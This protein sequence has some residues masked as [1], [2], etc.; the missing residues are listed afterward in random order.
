[1]K[2]L[3]TV[4]L[5][6]ILV[7]IP[8][9]AEKW[10]LLVGINS[11]PNDI[12]N[13]EYCVAD[14]QAFRQALV[15]VAGFKEDKIFLMTDGMADRMEPTHINVIA[16]LGILSR[17]VKADDT[18]VFYFSGHGIVN[19]GNSFLL[20]ANSDTTT[21]DTLERSA[22]PLDRVS[23]ILS[24]VKAQQ[25]LTVI[26][27]CRNNTAKD[28]SEEDNLLTHDF[29]K[30]F[31]IRRRSGSGKPSVS[32]ILYACNIGER[33]YEWPEKKHGVFSYYLLE[34]LKGEAVNN[35]G[36]VTISQLADY[37]QTRVTEWA[38][39]YKS[40]KQTPWL[41]LQG[42][43]KLVLATLGQPADPTPVPTAESETWLLVKNSQD[44]TDFEAFLA[45]FPHGDYALAAKLKLKQLRPK[46]ELLPI[47]PT[48]TRSKIEVEAE[49]I[50]QT[51][52]L[53][54]K[55]RLTDF[56]SKQNKPRT[57]IYAIDI[58]SS[59]LNLNP[60]RL[61]RIRTICQDSLRWL[62]TE[63]RF[64]LLTFGEEIEY[65][66]DHYAPATREL[67]AE[68]TIHF[69]K[70][71]PKE[72][73]QASDKDMISA[74]KSMSK[75]DP[76]IIVLFSD[77]ILTTAGIPD[78][79]K[80]K[81]EVPAGAKVFAMGAEMSADFPGAVIMR[82]LAEQSEGEFW[83]VGESEGQK[84]NQ[85][86]QVMTSLRDSALS[87]RRRTQA[88]QVTST[89][90]PQKITWQKDGAEMV[91]I[92][93]G[94][95]EMQDHFKKGEG[96]ALPVHTIELDAFYMDIHEVTVGRYKQF[97][98]ETKHRQPSWNYVNKYSPTDA[99]PIIHVD[100]NDATAY[101][102]WAGK[103]L[104]TEAEWEYA[105]RGGLVGKRYP[106][107]NEITHDDA[108]YL[109]IGG[110]DKWEG[111]VDGSAAP[112]GSF[113]PN[114]YGLFDMA[115]NVWEWCADSYMGRGGS[116]FVNSRDL[117]VA[118]RF[119]HGNNRNEFFG[120]RCVS[121]SLPSKTSMT[122]D[123]NGGEI[124][125]QETQGRS[126][127]IGQ[128][129]VQVAQ[130]VTD[131]YPNR[132]VDIVLLLD[133]SGS[134]KENILAV[135][136]H[137]SSMMSVFHTSQVDF[138]VG[139]VTFKYQALIFGLTKDYKR[140]EDLLRNVDCGGLERPFNAIMEAINQVKF[141]VG[142]SKRFLLVTDEPLQDKGRSETHDLP[143]VLQHCRDHSVVVD[144]IG[145]NE[146]SSKNL[147][148]QTGGQWFS[149]AHN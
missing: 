41:S 13:L 58:S 138:T 11:Y 109:G 56:L 89:Q 114:G 134:M 12:S 32:A 75:D 60:L 125:K 3:S 80:I 61:A 86:A 124:K 7:V 64:N 40:K 37:T 81:N 35:Q 34:G 132:R 122:S 149:I 45:K 28:K 46:V 97:L 117:G 148:Q 141:R 67:K 59:M 79:S 31:K 93:A 27:A 146:N 21:I 29:T 63:D 9:Q 26:D 84:S 107:G 19:N 133:A 66:R 120:I 76:S 14:V 119:G 42:G 18:F 15:S 54:T 135:S 140:Y 33:A 143:T 24:A 83:L 106:W 73:A 43:T 10:A 87:S 94:S 57:I 36:E 105:A 53:G 68:A 23:K 136:E 82:T 127:L 55:N 78:S 92:P 95:F 74:L 113:E 131:S 47:K 6:I 48:V 103:R 88:T 52:D 39:I 44:I 145:K 69:D 90:Q 112:V 108:N 91:L 130:S 1:M 50:N 71:V 77:G 2:R 144:V 4:L 38:R 126:E 100:W 85:Q 17:Q 65:W 110:R 30:G 96:S 147:A 72:T 101:T 25:L 104:P 98:A 118:I 116:W 51:V 22:I 121:N 111:G 142:A 115:G 8:L 102:K 20:A 16:R 128:A 137:L 5:L 70:I 49:N 62:E 139:I 129:M 99:H 123:Q